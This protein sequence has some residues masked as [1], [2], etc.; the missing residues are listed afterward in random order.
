M[1]TGLIQDLG[2]VTAYT[3]AG[4]DV[5]LTITAQSLDFAGAP[6]GASIACN[7]ICLT[8]TNIEGKEFTVTASAE[9]IAKTTLGQWQKGARIN[10]ER[11]LRMGDELGGHIVSGHVDGIATCTSVKPDGESYRFVFKVPGDLA[12]FI[13]SKG[14]VTVDGVSLT[15]NEVNANT[16]GVNIIPYTFQHTR[17]GQIKEGDA[18]NIEIDM[19]ARYVARLAEFN[20]RKAG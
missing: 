17:F 10:L 4:A 20:L 6:L 11:P 12:P 14:S 9:T 8:A 2:T 15:V 5:H 13:A 19:L 16:F 1:F 18:V 3:K 7:G